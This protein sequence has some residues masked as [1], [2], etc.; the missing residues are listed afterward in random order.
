MYNN[1]IKNDKYPRAQE[2]YLSQK[3]VIR[4]VAIDKL[5]ETMYSVSIFE[6]IITF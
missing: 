6:N 4:E 2:Q 1:I 5:R 3:Q